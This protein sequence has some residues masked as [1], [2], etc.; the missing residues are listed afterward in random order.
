MCITCV[1]DAY[2]DQKR[3]SDLPNW[4]YDGCELYACELSTRVLGSKPRSVGKSKKCSRRGLEFGSQLCVK[5]LT[6]AWEELW[7]FNRHFH[8]RVQTSIGTLYSHA[9]T[10]THKR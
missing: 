3:A 4:S 5:W 2:R 7:G 6:T 8:L 9:L 1:S 10:L